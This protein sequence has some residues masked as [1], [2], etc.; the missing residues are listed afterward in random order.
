[1]ALDTVG[2]SDGKKARLRQDGLAG[3]GHA[4]VIQVHNDPPTCS[5]T[6]HVKETGCACLSIPASTS[7]PNLLSS[8]PMVSSETSRSRL[9]SWLDDSS[10]TGR[11]W[12]PSVCETSVWTRLLRRSQSVL[13]LSTFLV[14]FGS[15]LTPFPCDIFQ[16][17]GRFHTLSLAFQDELEDGRL[18][19]QDHQVNSNAFVTK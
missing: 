8:I 1:M 9:G 7:P 16:L 2:G 19:E 5:S 13:F 17:V 11:Y 3:G 18:W 6:V 12:A 14:S 4:I 15:G 10:S